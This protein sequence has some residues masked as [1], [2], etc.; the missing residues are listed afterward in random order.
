ME[1]LFDLD[2]IR[3][4]FRSLGWTEEEATVETLVFHRGNVRTGI[5]DVL[6]LP[7]VGAA[8]ANLLRQ[9][10]VGASESTV[11]D[12]IEFLHAERGTSTE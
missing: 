4:A 2:Q 1:P 9:I 6:V 12:L 10:A 7:R 8:S 3:S 5:E 11:E